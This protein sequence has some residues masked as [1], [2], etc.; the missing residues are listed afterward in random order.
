MTTAQKQKITEMAANGAG[1]AII[2][3]TIGV[4]KETVRSFCRYHGLTAEDKERRFCRYCGKPVVS[5]PHRK[6]RKFC[7]DV[8]RLAW[9]NS[10]PELVKRRNLHECVCLSCGVS[11]GSKNPSQKYCSRACYG[12]AQKKEK[13]H[14]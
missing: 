8:C 11:F 6:E 1:Y 13:E 12:A 2:S 10:H 3:E 9:W 7:S 14:G 4:P 5:L